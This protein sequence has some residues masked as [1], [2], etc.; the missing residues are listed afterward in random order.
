MQRSVFYQIQRYIGSIQ[1]EFCEYYKLLFGEQVWSWHPYLVK[2]ELYRNSQQGGG[3][4]P[5]M[6]RSALEE[7]IN[8]IGM[9]HRISISECMRQLC[10]YNLS[11]NHSLC[12]LGT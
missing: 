12:N 5:K 3:H 6:G 4:G 8:W 10:L 1:L 9:W 7:P 11:E 2:T